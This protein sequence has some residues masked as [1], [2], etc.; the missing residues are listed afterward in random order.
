MGRLIR[1]WRH[2]LLVRVISWALAG[3][4]PELGEQR[5]VRGMRWVLVSIEARQ[6]MNPH[7]CILRLEYV[8]PVSFARVPRPRRWRGRAADPA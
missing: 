8:A 1:R 6:S 2:S 5:M 7:E 3:T 4:E